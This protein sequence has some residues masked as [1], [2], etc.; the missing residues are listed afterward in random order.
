MREEC[1]EAANRSECVAKCKEREIVPININNDGIITK[2]QDG[3][4]KKIRLTIVTAIT[5][6][7]ICIWLFD[8]L[9]PTFTLDDTTIKAD[10]ISIITNT[11]LVAKPNLISE[12]IKTLA[13]DT[14]FNNSTLIV[15]KAEH[16]FTNNLEFVE[17]PIFSSGAEYVLSMIF[18]CEVGTV[19][20]PLPILTK[21]E[22][23]NIWETLMVQMKIDDSDSETTAEA[24]EMVNF[25]KKEMLEFIKQGGDPDEFL[26]F[27]HNEL[28]KAYGMRE[29]FRR[30]LEKTIEENPIEAES[31]CINMNKVLSE[32]GI[33]LLNIDL[34]NN[35]EIAISEMEK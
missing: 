28:R 5:A 13:N 17:K 3:K 19:P 22:R 32:R 15:I 18:N 6:I 8:K 14:K 31:L 2:S 9:N 27:Y 11:N 30:E 16:T 23:K 25:A 4:Y 24:K 21:V 34:K 35:D 29:L 20:A 12:T 26:L 1:I 7:V 33:K 10:K